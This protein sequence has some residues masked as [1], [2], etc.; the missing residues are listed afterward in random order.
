M[1]LKCLSLFRNFITIYLDGIME[2]VIYINLTEIDATVIGIFLILWRLFFMH[3]N[4][5]IFCLQQFI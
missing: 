2:L 4:F 5:N 3:V 1:K